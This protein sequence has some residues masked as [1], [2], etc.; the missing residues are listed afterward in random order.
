[1]EQGEQKSDAQDVAGLPHKC[2]STKVGERETAPSGHRR[3]SNGNAS[4]WPYHLNEDGMHNLSKPELISVL[5]FIFAIKKINDSSS[6]YKTMQKLA[7]EALR[8]DELLIG[9]CSE[10][11][12]SGGCDLSLADDIAFDRSEL[13]QQEALAG[14]RQMPCRSSCGATKDL[15][16]AATASTDITT[17]DDGIMVCSYSAK[18]P[19]MCAAFV[20]QDKQHSQDR[21]LLESLTP[22]LS[23]AIERI[24]SNAAA[25]KKCGTKAK[26][27]IFLT[28]REKEILQWVSVG[29]SCGETGSILGITERTIKF[30]LQNVYRK[31]EVVNRAQAV[32][33]AHQH[34][35][36]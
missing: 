11:T 23:A 10:A 3:D 15:H 18:S 26:E 1:M 2:R 35:L 29:K 19:L 17:T 16:H 20:A 22:Y 27:I 32:T 36:L 28:T 21:E 24:S 6:L 33:V 5:D 12:S 14:A 31:L 25:A 9:T 8:C 13:D 7:R 4:N 34:A 30:H